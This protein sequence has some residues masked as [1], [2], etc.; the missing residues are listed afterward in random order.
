[1]KIKVSFSRLRRS[2]LI[3]GSSFKSAI[4]LTDTQINS[5]SFSLSFVLYSPAQN[6][7]QQWS[8]FSF[9][10]RFPHSGQACNSRRSDY[11]G[12]INKE[13]RRIPDYYRTK[14]S[15]FT[16]Q[17]LFSINTIPL[18]PACLLRVLDNL[19]IF[20][21]CLF[22]SSLGFFAY[23]LSLSITASPLHLS[24]SS[25]SCFFADLDVRLLSSTESSPSVKERK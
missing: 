2:P 21:V 15:A 20:R 23:L 19:A 17:A 25:S 7:Q 9:L 1:M 8:S 22:R 11:S 13:V 3:N 18:P 24:S 12:E 6:E 5:L 10:F 14:I 16:R 4:L